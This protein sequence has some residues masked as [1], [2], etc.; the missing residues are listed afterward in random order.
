M[1]ILGTIFA[2]MI[3]SDLS[4]ADSAPGVYEIYQTAQTFLGTL[5]AILDE[6]IAE[7][8]KVDS[9][10]SQRLDAF[11]YDWLSLVGYYKGLFPLVSDFFFNY[12][13]NTEFSKKNGK[14]V[15]GINKLLSSFRRGSDVTELYKHL[16]SLVVVS[17]EEELFDDG[18]IRT[19]LIELK[20]IVD[21][22]EK[23][24]ILLGR[25]IERKDKIVELLSFLI[26]GSPKPSSSHK[27]TSSQEEL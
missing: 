12:H 16:N 8:S 26:V 7:T 21:D 2:V 9:T 23:C 15:S 18:V 24:V 27:D 20:A 5:H 3:S 17:L 14:L 13:A 6:G 25:A 19:F 4:N 22:H 10:Y 1:R 11:K